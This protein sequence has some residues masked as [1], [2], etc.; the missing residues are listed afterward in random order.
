LTPKYQNGIFLDGIHSD[1]NAI[2]E[3]SLFLKYS[4]FPSVIDKI[5]RFDHDLSQN[6]SYYYTNLSDAD[7]DRSNLVKAN[8]ID[9]L[10]PNTNISALDQLNLYLAPQFFDD[11]KVKLLYCY[12][13]IPIIKSQLHANYG[14]Q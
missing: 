14:V 2:S 11:M 12:N 3:Q 7:E 5:S 10:P 13:Q 8:K 4:V 6:I 9:T 1:F